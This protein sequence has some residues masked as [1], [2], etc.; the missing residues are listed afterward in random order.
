MAEKG[1]PIDKYELNL[2]NIKDRYK[3][4]L[5]SSLMKNGIHDDN[6]E[7]PHMFTG[8][9]NDQGLLNKFK[10]N[11]LKEYQSSLTFHISQNKLLKN[12]SKRKDVGL[13]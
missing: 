4:N 2:D 6:M 13:N 3:N 5:K 10:K 11:H 8:V 9:N 1:D 7:M 12:P